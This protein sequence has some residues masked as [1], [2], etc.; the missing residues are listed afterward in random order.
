MPTLA[1]NKKGKYD[2]EILESFEAGLILLGH[3]VKSIRAG[4]L[5]LKGA[6]ATLH[7]GTVL[8]HNMHVSP[9]KFAHI[10]ASYSPTRSRPL[11]L[12]QSQIGK[13]AGQIRSKGLTLVPLSL[14]TKGKRIKVELGV[15][16]GKK[17]FEKRAIIAKR[18][19]DREIR[20]HLKR[21]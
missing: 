5:S 15:G 1:I 8:L 19:V 2:Y 3:E 17:Q 9:Y 7:D 12:R 10:D 6:F 16:R 4:H 14:Y 13:I 21:G 18:T 11:L 20:T